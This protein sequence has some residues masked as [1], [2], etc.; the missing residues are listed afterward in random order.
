[1]FRERLI[2][3][4][5]LVVIALAVIITGGPVLA[6]VLAAISVIGMNEL[7][8]AIGVED[9]KISPL[10]WIGYLGCIV[11]YVMVFCGQT[12]YTMTVL[13]VL[14]ILFMAVYVFTYPRY[15]TDQVTGAFFGIVY[16][17]VMLSCIYQLRTMKN[18]QY[19]VWLIFL[20][21]WGCD[22]CA[23]CVGMLIG[24]HKM[25]PKLS[26][27]KSVEGAVGGVVGAALLGAVYAAFVSSRL[28]SDRNSIL[29]F[30]VI[31]AVGALI[32]M[33]GDLA[34][35]AIKRNHDIKDY[36]RLIPGH[37]GILDRFDSVIFIAP[38]I[39]YLAQALMGAL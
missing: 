13:V 36:G 32:S 39:Y 5:L 22:T 37:G 31:C 38:V 24:K 17:A 34:A 2:S 33:I 10:A 29:I 3:G 18:G 25:S 1:M 16:V 7:Y 23:Y 12:A 26:P 19:L 27:K 28:E 15:K 4:I 30:A 6:V 20:A 9:K 8:R 11:Y 21:S 14:L 35:S